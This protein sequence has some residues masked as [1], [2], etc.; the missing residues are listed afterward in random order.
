MSKETLFDR[1]IVGRNIAL[2][3]VSRKDFDQYLGS[4]PDVS[5]KSV[6]MFSVTQPPRADV[7]AGEEEGEEEG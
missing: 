1:R 5:E 7:S 4:L 2:G 6:P 3:R